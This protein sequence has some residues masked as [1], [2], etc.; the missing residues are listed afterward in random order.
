MEKDGKAT[1]NSIDGK[2]YFKLCYSNGDPVANM[3]TIDAGIHDKGEF[4]IPAKNLN[5]DNPSEYKIIQR[6]EP[7]YNKRWSTRHRAPSRRAFPI[8]R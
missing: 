4:F 5:L 1:K 8:R 7:S 6:Y 2:G 3:P